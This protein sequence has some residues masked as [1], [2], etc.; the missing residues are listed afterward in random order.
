MTCPTCEGFGCSLCDQTGIIPC[1]RCGTD[2]EDIHPVSESND[3]TPWVSCP[4]CLPIDLAEIILH[5]Q[6]IGPLQRPIPIPRECRATV[7]PARAS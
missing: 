4:A 1:S 2:A 7:R 3:G 6:R 5:A